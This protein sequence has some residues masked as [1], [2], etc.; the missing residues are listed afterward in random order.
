ML[1][2]DSHGRG[3]WLSDEEAGRIM[4]ERHQQQVLQIVGQLLAR[5]RPDLEL[6]GVGFNPVTGHLS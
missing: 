3:A 5:V 4:E 1:D 6:D 2:L